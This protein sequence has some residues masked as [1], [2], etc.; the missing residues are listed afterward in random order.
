MN[1][2]IIKYNAKKIESFLS[3]NSKVLALGIAFKGEPHTDDTR[4]SVGLKMI[5]Y[6]KEKR[7]K[8]SCF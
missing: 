2:D 3:N 7:Q 4:D 5:N 6:L 8:H 1:E